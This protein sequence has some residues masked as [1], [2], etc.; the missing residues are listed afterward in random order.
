LGAGKA[1][2]WLDDAQRAAKVAMQMQPVAETSARVAQGEDA[3][4]AFH[5]GSPGNCGQPR[6][7]DQQGNRW[8][9]IECWVCHKRG[10]PARHCKNVAQREQ[11]FHERQQQRA[12]ANVA[13]AAAAANV[14]AAAAA[15]PVTSQQPRHQE[16]VLHTYEG[17]IHG[18]E[19]ILDSGAGTH[20]TGS[21]SKLHNLVPLAVPVEVNVANKQKLH[22]THKGEVSVVSDVDGRQEPVKFTDVLYVPGLA[23]N[24]DGSYDA[25]GHEQHQQRRS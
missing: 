2:A 24:L 25:G 4:A 12:A 18:D 16:T 7:G 22:P 23:V 5:R 20:T 8:A 21:K 3:L 10:H 14:A 19:W 11:F 13:A 6:H 17:V 15:A 1:F 9:N